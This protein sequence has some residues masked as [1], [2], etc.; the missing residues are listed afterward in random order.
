MLSVALHYTLNKIKPVA[1]TPSRE[2]GD[3]NYGFSV[4]LNEPI[5]LGLTDG[6]FIVAEITGTVC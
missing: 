2:Y 1:C 6:L 5:P 4:N 3:W